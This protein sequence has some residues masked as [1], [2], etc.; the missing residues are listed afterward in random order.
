MDS[1]E[2]DGNLDEEYTPSIRSSARGKKVQTLVPNS[3][4]LVQGTLQRAGV[5]YFW[6][7]V[8]SK[9][10]RRIIG[11]GALYFQPN[12]PRISARRTV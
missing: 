4:T 1:D 11:T 9:G 5:F 6:P 3:R 7:S 10:T 2:E 8:P 12:V